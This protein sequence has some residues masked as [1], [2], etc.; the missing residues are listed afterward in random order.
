[1]KRLIAIAA[2][3]AAA[4]AGAQS[5]NPAVTQANL[6]TTVCAKPVKG[7]PSWIRQQRP[8]SSY[9]SPIKLALC[10]AQGVDCS[11]RILDHTVPIEIG[12]APRDRANLQLQTKPA[13]R[14]KDVLENRAHADLC[15][16]RATLRQVQARF[17]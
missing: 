14:A 1:M 6:P 7:K 3:L 16:G 12:G 9:T 4:S 2:L 5:A 11:A 10:K 15:A 17:R 8:S 13:S